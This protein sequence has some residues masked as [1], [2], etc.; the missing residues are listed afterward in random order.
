LKY[1]HRS[2]FENESSGAYDAALKWGY[3]DEICKHMEPKANINNRALYAFEFSDKSVYVGLTW[4]YEQRYANHKNN[5]ILIEKRKTEKEEFVAYNEFFPAKIA[6]AKEQELVN[7]YKSN[8]WTIL[9][10]AAAGALGAS[11]AFWTFNRC[12]EEAKKYKTKQQFRLGSP[13]C[14]VIVCRNNW[15]DEIYKNCIDFHSIV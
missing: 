9:N 13:S 3:M 2:D 14:Y 7:L 10:K 4:N 11:R 15:K 8:G 6:G 12:L 5:P 1:K